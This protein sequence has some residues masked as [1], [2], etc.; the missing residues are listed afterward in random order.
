M[1]ALCD[2]PR[3]TPFFCSTAPQAFF[4]P[5]RRHVWPPRAAAVNDGPSLGPPEGLVIDGREHGGMLIGSGLQA[6]A[7]SD[8]FK[9]L[10]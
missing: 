6:L 9:P 8:K 7:T 1:Q 2:P 3:L 4:R 5:D 10:V